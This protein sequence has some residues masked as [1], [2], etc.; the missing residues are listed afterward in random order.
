MSRANKI[1]VP[2]ITHIVRGILGLGVGVTDLAS[3]EPEA[4]F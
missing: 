2:S 4:A 1:T 3:N